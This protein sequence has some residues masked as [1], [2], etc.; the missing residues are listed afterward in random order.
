VCGFTFR[1]S[2]IGLPLEIAG[3][4]SVD[5]RITY[6]SSFRDGECRGLLCKKLL[7]HFPEI[8]EATSMVAYHQPASNDIDGGAAQA[9]LCCFSPLT[10]LSFT[11][12]GRIDSIGKVS[13]A[14]RRLFES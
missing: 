1:K 5:R 3:S 9:T 7:F 12:H 10:R 6:V 4:C 13:R 11:C 8:P 14:A 2:F